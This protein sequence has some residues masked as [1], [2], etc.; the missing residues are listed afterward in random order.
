MRFIT[1]TSGKGG[2]GRTTL[3][4]N[5]GIALASLHKE[6]I[7][8]DG[9]MT[10]PDLG[11]LFKLEKAV[12]T[13]NDV[14]SGE[15]TLADAI[16]PGPKNVKVVPAAVTIEQ[17]QKAD[18]ERLLGVMSQVPEKTD[19]VLIDSPCGLRRET[20]AAIR[21]GRE[22]LLVATPD[23]ISIS[24]LMKTKLV[25]EL[26]GLAPIGMVLNRV[27]GEEFELPRSKIQAITNISVLAEIPEDEKVRQ[28]LRLG[29]PLLQS[30][31]RS[32]A[33]EAIKELAK[34]LLKVRGKVRRG[35]PKA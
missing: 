15:A 20:V 19:F 26:L 12:Y 10:A 9:N 34:K 1:V 33:A 35:A 24:D 13:L 2:V 23:I 11:L 4:A 29:E 6:T 7:I 21:A 14:L 17:I 31:P 16:Y 18:P 32:P 27:R 8:I 30:S 28:A 5:L 3:V 25:T 22:A